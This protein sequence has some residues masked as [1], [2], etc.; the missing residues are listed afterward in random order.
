LVFGD[1]SP[2]SSATPR[3]TSVKAR[4]SNRR[5]RQVADDHSKKIT[6]KALANFSPGGVEV[7]ALKPWFK[8]PQKIL[9]NSEGVA[10]G[11]RGGETATQSLQGCVF[12]EIACV[13][14]GLPKRNATTPFGLRLSP[15]LG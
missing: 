6:L 14:P 10:T 13:I 7:F 4:Q 8:V 12:H 9:R 5:L 2:P 3:Y 11:L 1:L 15:G